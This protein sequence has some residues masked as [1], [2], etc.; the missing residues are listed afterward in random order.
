MMKTF[1]SRYVSSKLTLHINESCTT[2]SVRIGLVNTKDYKLFLIITNIFYRAGAMLE[3]SKQDR[4]NEA[5][6]QGM[7]N[8]GVNLLL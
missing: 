8:D 3:F 1:R 7:Y 6:I 5:Y 2:N 4:P